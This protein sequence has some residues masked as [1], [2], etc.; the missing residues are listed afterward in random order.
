LVRPVSSYLAIIHVTG[1]DMDQDPL[2]KS[3]G[4]G[5]PIS[6]HN[7]KRADKRAHITGTMVPDF[8]SGHEEPTSTA[9]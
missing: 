4:C 2:C 6:A 9:A 8:P 1:T 5:H 7:V 3:D